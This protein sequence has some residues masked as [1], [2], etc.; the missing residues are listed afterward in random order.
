[1]ERHLVIAD[2]IF[3]MKDMV[4]MTK[5][6]DSIVLPTFR[7][8]LKI[9]VEEEAG[10]KYTF[11]IFTILYSFCILNEIKNIENIGY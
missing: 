10:R 6:S 4:S 9:K 7:D 8:S 11:P 3:T 2:Q 5:E 1:M